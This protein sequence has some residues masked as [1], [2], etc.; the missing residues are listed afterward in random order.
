MAKWTGWWKQRGLGRQ[1]MHNLVLEVG[2]DGRVVGG[3]DDCV[4]PFTFRGQFR[5][6]GT[7]SLL[8]QYI[9]RHQVV[10]EGCNSGEGVFGT[11]R[12]GFDAGRF[13]LRPV[14]GGTAESVEI[15]QLLPAG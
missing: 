7:V 4:G 1:K 13:A 9:G 6:D 10:Y 2:P 5:P 3:G 8:K 15:E 12:I 14:A 11:W